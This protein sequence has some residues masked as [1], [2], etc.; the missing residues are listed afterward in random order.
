V[1]EVLK[2]NPKASI[3]GYLKAKTFPYKDQADI[4]KVVDSLR[5]AGMPE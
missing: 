5:K 3:S 2:R 1:A 4:D